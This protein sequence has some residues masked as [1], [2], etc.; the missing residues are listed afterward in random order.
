MAVMVELTLKTDAATYQA[1]HNQILPAA[2]AHG[3]LFHSGREV[4]GGV[5]VVDF[6]PSAEA[7]QA[8]LDGPI[9]DGMA[10]V[11]LEAPDDVRI[12]E[13]LTA[14]GWSRGVSAVAR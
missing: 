1:M 3:L 8:F 12:T 6:W 11:G 13:V 14:D 5:G 9:A 7:F 2:K 10:A 4:D